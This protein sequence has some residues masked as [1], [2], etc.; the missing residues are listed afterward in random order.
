QDT[1]GYPPTHVRIQEIASRLRRANGNTNP[2]SQKW[3]PKF[4]QRNLR[5]TY[6]IGRR[7]EA[8]RI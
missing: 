2:L 7:I 4:I 3:A 8:S 5:V 1:R 6:I